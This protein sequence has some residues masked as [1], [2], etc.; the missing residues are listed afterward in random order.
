MNTARA[1]AYLAK[2]PPAVAG[3]CGH[4]ATFSAACRLVEFGLTIEQAAPLLAAWNETHC[5]PRW[6]EAELNHKLADAFKR[7]VPKPE[8]IAVTSRRSHATAKSH[9]PLPIHRAVSKTSLISN[10]SAA[11][12]PE[13][14]LLKLAPHFQPG[15]S[16]DIDALAQLR[17]LSRAGIDVAR[18]RGLLRFGRYHGAPAWF[19]LDASHRN[20]CARRM[21]G[22]TW[23]NTGAKSFVFRGADASRPIG[24]AEAQPF[25]VILLC[26]GAPDLLAAFHFIATQGRAADCAPV[27]MLS[28]AYNIPPQSLAMFAGKRVRIF[29]HSD[30]MG[31]SAAARWR[32]QLKSHATEIDAFSFAGICDR[33]GDDVK[34]L[35]GF[36]N[37]EAS[38]ENKNHL[39]NLLP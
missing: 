39:A 9:S 2:L 5:E 6:T 1:A 29:A 17:G 25:D 30:A 38:D 33:A 22:A 11:N 28:A 24:I 32:A 18:S 19:V 35:N 34:D 8:F 37:C 36:A 3:N 21:D 13:P 20:G 14:E 26:E 15:T 7:T 10:P 27:A 31:F 4:R 12:F 16:Q 23:G